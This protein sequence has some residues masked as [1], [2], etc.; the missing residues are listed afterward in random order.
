MIG[1][2]EELFFW[3]IEATKIYCLKFLAFNRSRLPF[4]LFI[5]FSDPPDKIA[6][7]VLYPY[8]SQYNIRLPD[9][10]GRIAE[11]IESDAQSARY[12]TKYDN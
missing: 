2:Q 12:D 5:L 3:K 9:M 11:D 10:I 7:R 6:W 1:R 8:F 4:S